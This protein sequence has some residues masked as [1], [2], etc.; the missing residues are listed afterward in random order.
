MIEIPDFI[1]VG[2]AGS[3]PE[4]VARWWG[5]TLL[6]IDHAEN[7]SARKR[8]SLRALMYAEMSPIATETIQDFVG[9]LA[10]GVECAYQD[11]PE[12]TSL[13][14]RGGYVTTTIGGEPSD[15]LSEAA[16][17]VGIDPEWPTFPPNGL[18]YVQDGIAYA[19]LGRNAAETQI[20]LPLEG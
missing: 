15:I 14:K 9:A 20:W 16:R 7:S 13:G 18:T 8:P 1:N 17:S 2:E 11:A 4:A 3:A 19:S 6:S 5:G 10:A 12:D